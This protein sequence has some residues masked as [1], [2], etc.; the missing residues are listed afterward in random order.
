LLARL[1]CHV[2]RS[3]LENVFGIVETRVPDPT[4]PSAGPARLVGYVFGQYW[5]ELLATAKSLGYGL[6]GIVALLVLA[7]VLRRRRFRN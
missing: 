1:A 3:R 2:Q 4:A 7:Y 5:E 6:I